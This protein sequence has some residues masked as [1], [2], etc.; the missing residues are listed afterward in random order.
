MATIAIVMAARYTTGSAITDQ[1][2]KLRNETTSSG[3]SATGTWTRC[4]A[5]MEKVS[6][7]PSKSWP[8]RIP[9][10]T[11]TSGAGTRLYFTSAIVAA[12]ASFFTPYAAIVGASGAVFGVLF[13]FARYWPTARIYF[14]GVIPIQARWFIVLMAVYSIWAGISG[15]GRVAH[16]AHLGGLVGGWLYLKVMEQRSRANRFRKRAAPKQP[17]VGQADIDRWRELARS[18]RLHP[19]NREELERILRKVDQQG[20]ASLDRGERD[21]LERLSSS[22]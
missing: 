2:G 8:T 15:G 7:N 21:F 18:E 20:A 1:S 9:T 6:P 19:V 12:L 13:G 16:F 4:A 10:T 17:R 11:T 14:W 3:V 5:P 22:G